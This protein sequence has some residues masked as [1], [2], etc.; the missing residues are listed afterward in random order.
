MK[1]KKL[2][3]LAAWT[4]CT[5]N[6]SGRVKQATSSRFRRQLPELN[7][8]DDIRPRKRKGMVLDLVKTG[9]KE[10]DNKDA[11]TKVPKEVNAQNIDTRQ[12][13]ETR[14]KTSSSSS[15]DTKVRPRPPKGTNPQDDEDSEDIAFL[16]SKDI[17]S[18][19]KRT[20]KR[21]KKNKS[22]TPKSKLKTKHSKKSSGKG[23]GKGGSSSKGG[24]LSPVLPPSEDGKFR[25][26]TTI[27]SQFMPFI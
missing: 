17:S 22:R 27:E 7:Y 5:D 11:S 1:I 8:Q 15:T 25:I 10:S 4:I 3:L 2:H 13:V 9:E 16:D 19:S 26:I 18:S 21:D 6:A 12:K 14:K 20:K 24:S 23:T